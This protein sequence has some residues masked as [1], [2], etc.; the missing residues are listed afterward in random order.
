MKEKELTQ[1]E[2]QQQE[3]IKSKEKLKNDQINKLR[4]FKKKI[5]AVAYK[6]ALTP[7]KFSGIFHNVRSTY[8]PR[9]NFI[10]LN[11]FLAKSCRNIYFSPL[12]LF[13]I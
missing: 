6:I 1:K 2:L 13:S 10:F 8:S 7:S 12:P 5:G 9:V 3:L 4:E 11:K